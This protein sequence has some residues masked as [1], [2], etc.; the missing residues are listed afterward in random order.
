VY[1]VVLVPDQKKNDEMMTVF[2]QEGVPKFLLRCGMSVEK[3]YIFDDGEN[4]PPRLLF[5]IRGLL[6]QK[7]C[8]GEDKESKIKL[9]K[10]PEQ[11][12]PFQKGAG[13][14]KEKFECLN[15]PKTKFSCIQDILEKNVYK[16]HYC[17]C[18]V[19][20]WNP[21]ERRMDF[22]GGWSVRENPHATGETFQEKVVAKLTLLHGHPD[23]PIKQALLLH[24]CG[25]LDTH[26]LLDSGK[27]MSN[28]R[29]A[30]GE[31]HEGAD[32]D[33]TD[34]AVGAAASVAPTV[35]HAV[36]NLIFMAI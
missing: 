16:M 13:K 23:D 25:G 10:L 27:A 7:L 21:K 5:S 24:Y 4:K 12:N 33:A 3:Y 28:M 6:S 29:V 8:L 36:A 11:Y 9:S 34:V 2:F 30:F 19:E 18:R 15:F 32:P 22:W 31:T 1:N 17:T 35:L 26:L 20:V 14:P